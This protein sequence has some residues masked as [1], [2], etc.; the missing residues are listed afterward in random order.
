MVTFIETTWRLLRDYHGLILDGLW[1]TV[2][3]AILCE[4]LALALGLGVA[5][6]RLS[7][8]RSLR[9][10]AA[11]Y[12]ELFRDTPFLVQLFWIYYALP[13]A[14]VVVD[15]WSAAVIAITLY[16]GSYKAEILR[17]GIQAVPRSQFLAARGLGMSK[18]QMYA[19][20][21]LP[22]AVRKMI[23]SLVSSFINLVKSTSFVSIITVNELT[24]QSFYIAAH[25]FHS[26]EII[27]AAALMYFAMIW[28]LNLWVARLEARLRQKD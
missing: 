21:V 22:Q 19:R 6:M 13:A 26:L 24:G 3:L 1:L 7:P 27:S 10:V 28:P 17:A 16:I 25:T 18:V 5:L 4:M 9:T 8:L 11:S 14:G 12:T 20:V 15:S 2:H 23:P